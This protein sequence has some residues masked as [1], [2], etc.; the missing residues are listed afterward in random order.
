MTKVN[1]P[2]KGPAL[3]FLVACVLSVVS[4]NGCGSKDVTPVIVAKY[5]GGRILENDL[6][7]GDIFS[8]EERLY[9]AKLSLINRTIETAFVAAEARKRGISPAEF[10]RRNTDASTAISGEELGRRYDDLLARA[11]RHLRTSKLTDRERETRILEMVNIDADSTRSFQELVMERLREQ[12]IQ[13]KERETV[14]KMIRH[15]GPKVYLNAPDPPIYTIQ[16]DGSPALG[17]NTAPVTIVVFS[18]FQCPYS[19]RAQPDLNRLVAKFS[20]QVRL[21]FR[22]YPL[23]GHRNAQQAAEA[24]SLAHDQGKFWQYHDLL[25]ANQ[26]KLKTRD[27]YEYARQLDLDIDL[28]HQGM[29]NRKH[30]ARV[31][32]EQKA[33][34]KYGVRGT[35]AIYINGKPRPTRTTSYFN[36]LLPFVEE[37]LRGNGKVR[38]RQ[39]APSPEVLAE[40]AGVT[41]TEADIRE[42]IVRANH[43][44]DVLYKHEEGIYYLKLRLTEELLEQ[45]LT[46]LE[47][48]SRGISVDSLYRADIGSTPDVGE[49]ETQYEEFQ[50]YVTNNP[51][52]MH[53]GERE[54]EVEILR[55]LK[56]E[57]DPSL[58]FNEQVLRKLAG[59]VERLK[60]ERLKP[61]L[62]AKLKQRYG[63]T[64]KIE[65]P[66]PPTY[67]IDTRGHPSLGPE[68]APVT[69]V[70]FSDFECPYSKKA[71][72][73]IHEVLERFPE[74]VRL[75]FRHFPL[76][77]HKRAQLVHEASECAQEQ[78]KF[79]QYYDQ[80]FANEDALDE[81]DLKKHAAELGMDIV[82]FNNCL[83]NRRFE[84]KVKRDIREARAYHVSATPSFYVNGTPRDLRTLEQFAWHITGGQEGDPSVKQQ[85]AFAGSTCK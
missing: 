49:I 10:I 73:T 32:A 67:V 48:E 60:I 78:G 84:D 31:N 71:M 4:I 13:R 40:V 39:M 26:D 36:E 15:A 41:L 25:F 72:P 54:R 30:E 44:R 69:V 55:L 17:P 33:G 79:W 59:I 28:F 20:D 42:T 81:D 65:P 57:I 53:L 37:E 77:I 70:M 11:N 27:L 82:R 5:E 16:E 61:V 18:D 50:G 56:I 35:P 68:N 29:A 58:T 51:R 76:R 43:P 80:V 62:L 22:H 47:A 64:V 63:A 66:D 2:S 34:E 14:R 85:L 45:R 52:L 74:D 19:A 21:V 75:V 6:P 9:T 1:A 46:T 38:R 7:R 24:A 83:D 3:P 12:H 23:P 8:A